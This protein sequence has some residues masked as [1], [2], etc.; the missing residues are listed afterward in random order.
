MTDA[1]ETFLE[2]QRNA[3]DITS[4]LSRDIDEM[5]SDFTGDAVYKYYSE[6]RR[7]FFARPQVRFTQKSG[8]NDPF[9]LTRRWLEFGTAPTRDLFVGYLRSSLRGYLSRKDLIAERVR[10]TFEE[11]GQSLTSEQMAFV[12]SSLNGPQGE[13]FLAQQMSVIDAMIGS[14]F[15]NLAANSDKMIDDIISDIGILSVSETATNH[16]LWALYADSGKGVLRLSSRLSTN[17]FGPSGRMERTS[18]FCGG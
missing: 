3:F 2:Q 12:V 11:Q 1:L 17:S 10:A 18:I 8:L 9:E 5:E 6:S 16:Q 13:A 4:I 15:S 14:L 7:S